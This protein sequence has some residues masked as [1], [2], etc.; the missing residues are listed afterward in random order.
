MNAMAGTVSVAED[1][2]TFSFTLTASTHGTFSIAYSNALLTTI[3][4]VAI[5]TGSIASELPASAG[6]NVTSTVTSGP[7]TIYTL[8][9]ATPSLENFGVAPVANLTAAL[10]Y[11]LTSG[12]ALSF[13]GLNTLSLSG[14]VVGVPS[15]L[16]ETT[17]TTPIV[18]NFSPFTNGG[19]VTR[20]FIAVDG[21]FAGVILHGGAITGTGAF[22]DQA[23]VPE[24][25]SVALLGIGVSCFFAFRR[26]FKSNVIVR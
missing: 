22:A 8:T 9:Q 2:G 24:P 6:H 19:N 11:N 18:Y 12:G 5:P 23:A 13:L 3:N 1:G 21:N 17:A 7:L 14:N 15:A 26:C 25:T 4:N 20:T 16:L 10:Q